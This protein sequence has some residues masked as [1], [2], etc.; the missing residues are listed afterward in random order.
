[1]FGFHRSSNVDRII[2]LLG[3]IALILIGAGLLATTLY[4]LIPTGA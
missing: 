1:L 3:G 4:D 2:T